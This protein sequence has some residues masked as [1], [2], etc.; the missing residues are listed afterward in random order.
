MIKNFLSQILFLFPEQHKV[1][2][3]RP[4]NGIAGRR[5]FFF[6]QRL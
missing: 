4:W 3:P 2:Y 6:Q 5:S 1:N